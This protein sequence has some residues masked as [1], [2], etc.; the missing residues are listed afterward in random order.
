LTKAIPETRGPHLVLVAAVVLAI[1]LAAA[2]CA[3]HPG[4]SSD[5]THQDQNLTAYKKMIISDYTT[6]MDALNATFNASNQCDTVQNTGCPEALTAMIPHWQ[7]WLND[8][9]SYQTPS[10]Y[11]VIDGHLRRHLIEKI[12]ELN[13]AVAFQRDGNESGFSLAVEASSYEI[14]WFG[15][16]VD[17]VDGTYAKVAGSYHDAVNLAKQALDA[18][19]NSAPASRK[20]GCDALSHETCTGA[21][22]KN[23]AHDVEIAETQLQTFVVALLQDPAP[24][25]LAKQGAQLQAGLVQAD[26]ALLAIADALLRGDSAKVAAGQSSYKA[27]ITAADADASP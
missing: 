15:V 4:S 24:S 5:P 18:C 3:L 27:A 1:T 21:A 11:V 22:A 9:N 16:T 13:A 19:M 17:A 20:A 26:T 12:A 10:M 8:L 2:S 23:C 6:S 25:A 14:T 7:M